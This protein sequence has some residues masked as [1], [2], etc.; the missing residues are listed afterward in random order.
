MRFNREGAAGNCSCSAT[1]KGEL[2]SLR[3]LHTVVKIL[4]VSSE[5]RNKS[6]TAWFAVQ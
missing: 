3:I 1:C 2:V 6:T 5:G 4:I